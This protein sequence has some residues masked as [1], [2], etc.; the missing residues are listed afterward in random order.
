MAY[1]IKAIP[2]IYNGIQ[3]RSMLEARWAAFF[4]L[5]RCPFEYE[6][7]ILEGWSPDFVLRPGIHE[8]LVEIKP[9]NEWNNDLTNKIYRH[10]IENKCLLFHD[11]IYTHKGKIYLGK[12]FNRDPKNYLI[13][14]DLEISTLSD[15][16]E[17]NDYDVFDLWKEAKNIVQFLKPVK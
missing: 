8:Y 6:P 2:T 7:F 14:D 9:L 12:I 11:E 15:F 3:Y 16:E 5:I 10:S 17:Y 4:D 13:L 1:E